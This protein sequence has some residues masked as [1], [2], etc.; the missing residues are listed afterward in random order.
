M[1]EMGKKCCFV[2]ISEED[3]REESSG[4]FRS[5]IGTGKIRLEEGSSN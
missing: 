3:D 5:K 4:F 1:R 2:G